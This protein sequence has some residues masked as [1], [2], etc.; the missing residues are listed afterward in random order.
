MSH[1]IEV[2]N[3]QNPRI[4]KGLCGGRLICISIGYLSLIIF[5]FLV[6]LIPLPYGWVLGHFLCHLGNG[7][8]S[9]LQSWDS[10][11]QIS[12][13]ECCKLHVMPGVNRYGEMPTG[14]WT[15]FFLSLHSRICYNPH[16][17]PSRGMPEVICES[18]DGLETQ[19]SIKNN[20]LVSKTAF[21]S[22]VFA[23]TARPGKVSLTCS[24]FS[25]DAV[26][27]HLLRTDT[28]SH[29]IRGV[30]TQSLEETNIAL[31]FRKDKKD[32]PKNYK[33]MS[34]SFILENHFQVHKWQQSH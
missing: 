26:L 33:L 34:L 24:L 22:E 17:H 6:S 13:G 8:H 12:H 3:A 23:S 10:W 16:D 15:S 11:A 25:D 28:F 2:I 29:K 19:V 1:L 32:N 30:S 21:I 27:P 20:P 4:Y 5:L 14:T 7:W 18:M 31:I 9:S